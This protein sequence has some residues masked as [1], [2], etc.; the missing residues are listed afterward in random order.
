MDGERGE[1]TWCRGSVYV[2]CSRTGLFGHIYLAMY[3]A[4]AAKAG[5]Y[6][7]CIPVVVWYPLNTIPKYV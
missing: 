7:D 3:M 4:R 5:L 6:F 2:V 1:P